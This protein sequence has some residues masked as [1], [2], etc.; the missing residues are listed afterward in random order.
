MLEKFLTR[1]RVTDR[2]PAEP[3]DAAAGPVPEAVGE[4]FAAL[5]GA[6]VEHGLYRVHTPRTAAAANAVCGRLLRGFEQRMYCFGFDW[7]G[8]NLAV[9]L[10]TGEPADPHVVLVEPGAGELMESGIG[11][12]PFHDEVLVTD[13]SP[14][15]ADFFDQWRATQPGFERLAFDECV[16]YKVP[17][18]LGGED[19][20]HNLE[21]VP[22]DVYWD[23]CV[24]LRTGTRRMTPG[25]TIGRIVVDEEG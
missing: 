10:A 7:L 12:H 25:T 4:L 2:L 9:D 15:A 11:L 19:E 18:F 6:S 24:Q 3:A 22:Y 14:L 5:S 20:V 8:R 16:G 17:L 21:R 1:Y 13:T 23:L